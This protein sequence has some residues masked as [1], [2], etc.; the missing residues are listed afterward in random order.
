M[1][2]ISK[3]ITKQPSLHYW[4]TLPDRDEVLEFIYGFIRALHE[5]NPDLAQSFVMVNDMEFFIK[6]L[7]NSLRSY[8][9]M[10]IEDEEWNDYEEKN[11][12]FEV[13]DPALLD[14]SLTVPEFS[15]KQFVL[16]KNET[17]SMQVGM[18]EQVTTI[19]LHFVLI[20]SDELY[21]LKIQ[22]ITSK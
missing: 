9:N 6:T 14:E 10:V 20:E 8:L 11:L 12:A 7:D 21:Y 16:N 13:E 4:K 3:Y 5:K 18:R 19:R 15:G 17:V 1:P 2:T 22:R